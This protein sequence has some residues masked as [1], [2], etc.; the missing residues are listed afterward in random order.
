MSSLGAQSFC[1][2]CHEAALLSV[3]D[4][5]SKS[6]ERHSWLCD[7]KYVLKENNP[8]FSLFSGTFSVFADCSLF[9]KFMIM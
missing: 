1:W 3:K 6:Y 8:R 4:F 7:S 2:F 9:S 5:A